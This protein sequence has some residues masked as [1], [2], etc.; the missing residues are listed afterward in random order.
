MMKRPTIPARTTA[1]RPPGRPLPAGT[2]APECL[3]S[4]FSDSPIGIEIYDVN[5]RLLNINKACLGIFGVSKASDVKGF[6]LFEDPNLTDTAKEDLRRGKSVRYETPFDF[7]RVKQ[8]KLYPTQKSGI[9]HLLVVV[10]PLK[11]NFC[12]YLAQIQDIT[13]RKNVEQRLR[14]QQDFLSSV[15]NSLSNPFYVIDANDY[16]VKLMNTAARSGTE[17]GT[18]TCHALTHRCERP[19]G[20]S[21]GHRCPLQEV[22]RTKKPV[23][24]EHVL[25]DKDG[26]ARYYEVH[27]S[28]ILDDRG[29]VAQMIEYSIDIS[30]RKRMEEEL[31][32]LSLID[33]LTGLYNRRGFFTLAEKQLAL[34]KREGTKL[35][36]IYAD[37][38]NM[39]KINDTYGHK[40]GDVTLIEIN[41][42]LRYTFRESDIVARIGGDEFAILSV[43]RSGRK[44]GVLIRR[45]ERNLAN[46]NAALRK[47]YRLSM[48][49]GAACYDP[50]NPVPLDELLDQADKMMYKQK[51]RKKQQLKLGGIY[52]YHHTKNNRR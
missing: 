21:P 9:V 15:I 43:E 17:A 11:G 35:L 37:I 12:G 5:G 36:C 1:H 8:A 40:E 19:C 32:M 33:E 52:A 47:P 51:L 45:L 22:K 30:E 26:N 7:E 48:S 29:N 4:I 46:A 38:D 42:I 16:S 24:L 44:A 3:E 27:A 39:K 6:R 28:P 23:T 50:A 13:E 18:V 14:G 41:N 34:A 20:T 25:Y 10:T 49:A 31:H 2:I